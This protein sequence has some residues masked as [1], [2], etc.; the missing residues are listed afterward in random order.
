M[1]LSLHSNTA[2][3]VRLISQSEWSWELLLPAERQ[4][5]SPHS[6]LQSPCRPYCLCKDQS[7]IAL[8]CPAAQK[9]RGQELARY[10]GNTRTQALSKLCWGPGLKKRSRSVYAWERNRENFCS[11]IKVLF[12]LKIHSMMANR[13][14]QKGA[15]NVM[16][17]TASKCH[18]LLPANCPSI[19]NKTSQI[20]L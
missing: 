4:L 6:L 16:D 17:L 11:K 14:G 5:T 19:R 20:N 15:R 1:Q 18:L 3:C 9:W 12:S 13:S 7:V 10:L 8:C 2:V